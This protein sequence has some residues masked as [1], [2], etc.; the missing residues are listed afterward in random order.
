M[1]I[2]AVSRG[3]AFAEFGA[4]FP[5][6]V[7]LAEALRGEVIAR[8]ISPRASLLRRVSG[9]LC[10]AEATFSEL[11]KMLDQLI[12]TG[13]LLSGTG[14]RIAPAPVR[15]IELPDGALVLLG[16][17]TSRDIQA[18]LGEVILGVSPR[19]LSRNQ[20]IDWRSWLAECGGRWIRVEDWSRLSKTPPW[21]R[22]LE[23]LEARRVQEES[24][25][26]ATDGWQTLRCDPKNALRP[27]RFRDGLPSSGWGLIR[28]RE[29][30]YTAYRMVWL[31]RGQ[32]RSLRLTQDDARR[33]YC[34]LAAFAGCPLT[35]QLEEQ[36]GL[37]QVRVEPWLPRAEHA[38]LNLSNESSGDHPP[39]AYCFPQARWRALY[40]AL[41]TR[42]G[43]KREIP[44]T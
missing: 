13:D 9:R 28:R 21:E 39:G 15:I 44:R 5:S 6:S 30:T 8:T 27:R 1:K 2:F 4:G 43:W 19:R 31:E 14:R 33:T 23:Q 24:D 3:D 34:A 7:V 12:R 22:W 11:E 42:L 35:Y 18:R 25:A 16:G 26:L 41:T 36:D 20:G 40:P 10:L 32:T 29:A 37:V 17:V 38:V